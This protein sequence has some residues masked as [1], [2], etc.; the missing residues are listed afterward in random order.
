MRRFTHSHTHLNTQFL[1]DVQDYEYKI[2]VI[3]YII[4][5]IMKKEIDKS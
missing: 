5:I 3:I 4:S 1:N 2:Y